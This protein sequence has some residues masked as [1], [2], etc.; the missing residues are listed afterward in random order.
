ML[1]RHAVRPVAR[2][3][4]VRDSYAPAALGLSVVIVAVTLLVGALVGQFS[5]GVRLTL[6]FLVAVPFVIA[7]MRGTID[8]FEPVYFYSC[9]Y[10]LTY[11]GS[12]IILS[13]SD[14][15][16]MDYVADYA[17]SFNLAVLLTI[18]GYAAF[19][20]GYY[21]GWP[22][23]LARAVRPLW[24]KPHRGSSFLMGAL[25]VYL[26]G[27]VPR[28]VLLSRGQHLA[29]A[30]PQ[31]IDEMSASQATF[32]YFAWFA[33]FGFSL[34]TIYCFI[35]GGAGLWAAYGVMFA[36]ELLYAFLAGSKLFFLPIILG[37][38][39]AFNHL[40]RRIRLANFVIPWLAF[41][42]II[43]PVN[44]AYRNV[45]SY[46]DLK[47]G[48]IGT[49]LPKV[50]GLVSD[51]LRNDTDSGGVTLTASRSAE[52]PILAAVVKNVPSEVPLQ[53]GRTL[54]GLPLAVLIPTAIWPTKYDFVN[55]ALRPFFLIWGQLDDTS[56]GVAVTLVGELYFN[57]Y[58]PGVLIG[59]ALFG[60]LLRMF[61]VYL[62]D[63][64]HPVNL[65]IY[66]TMWPFVVVWSVESWAFS[67]VDFLV[68]NI[69]L[70]LII[71]WCLNSGRI[72][73]PTR[74]ALAAS[75]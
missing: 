68:K 8:W 18:A 29:Y 35:S 12:T 50:V 67:V 9:V 34:T 13:D 53:Y 43:V 65:A 20:V 61:Y 46:G 30:V 42:F 32:N 56:T 23:R 47:L 74:P 28:L 69:V 73:A 22:A 37:P 1:T 36:L 7:K 64:P 49:D 11:V 41:V 71:G 19:L 31:F 33:F 16:S 25:V 2:A 60:G 24:S 52:L 75:R 62:T 38:L 17:D 66:M 10:F 72:F 3:A 39:I 70:L 44:V 26:I 45:I 4:A 57:F 63:S 54:I 58:I 40:R 5:Y 48:T 27:W 21:S 15:S 55:E 51:A 59:M 6:L 14:W